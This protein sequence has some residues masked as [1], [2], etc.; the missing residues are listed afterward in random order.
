MEAFRIEQPQLLWTLLLLPAVG[1]LL[2]YWWRYR[3]RMLARLA[4][5]AALTQLLPDLPTA[6]YYLRRAWLLSGVLLALGVALSNPQLGVRETSV[7]RTG[8]DLFVALDISRS[9]LAADFPPNR[10]ER[11][12]RLTASLVKELANHNIGLILFTCDAFVAV[13]LTTDYQ[14]VQLALRTADPEQTDV[15]GT[16]LSSPLTR[17]LASFPADSRH[18]RAI[19]LISDGEG[20][21]RAAVREAQKA[22]EEGTFVFTVAT[23]RP[24]GAYI[25][26]LSG[27]GYLTDA[28]GRP[29]RS[30][31]DIQLLKEIASAGQGAS[32][33]LDTDTDALVKDLSARINAISKRSF[34][35]R[36]YADYESC[37]QWF[38]GLALLLLAVDWYVAAGAWPR[39]A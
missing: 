11:A 27:G 31:P 21:G 7:K 20:E 35:S 12:K 30:V 37:F 6:G 1:L 5:P 19:L 9:M 13:P 17:A 34:E 3:Q 28:T 36:T 23:G 14:F 33:T 32:Y 18:H 10:L 29:V 38:I 2:L 24:E 25:P 26:L 8:I 4:H 39:K 15:Q 16:D 22:R